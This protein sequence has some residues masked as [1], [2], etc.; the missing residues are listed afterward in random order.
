MKEPLDFSSIHTACLSGANGHGKSALLDAITW[1]LWGRARGV[2]RRGT[3]ADDLIHFRQNYMQVELTFELENQL[4][5]VVRFR[6]KSGR[7]QSRLELQIKSNDQFHSL[8]CSSIPETQERI[9]RL[10]RMDYETFTNSAFILQGKADSFTTKNPNDRKEILSEILGLSLYDKLEVKAKE[11]RRESDKSQAVIESKID[12][13]DQEIE[14]EETLQDRLKNLDSQLEAVRKQSRQEEKVLSGL[15]EQKTQFDI[16]TE[17]LK[18][19][20]A[21]VNLIQRDINSLSNQTEEYKEEI[22][23]AQN[24]ICQA[25]HINKSYQELKELQKASKLIDQIRLA[26]VVLSQAKSELQTKIKTLEQKEKEKALQIITAKLNCLREDYSTL[27]NKKAN[28]AAEN[29]SLTKESKKLKEKITLIS[30]KTPACPFCRQPLDIQ[31]R[32][33]LL[34]EFKTQLA[35]YQEQITLSNQEIS[36]LE[37]KQNQIN[38]QGNQLKTVLDTSHRI[39]PNS[40]LTKIKREPQSEKLTE[41]IH[42]REELQIRLREQNYAPEEQKKIRELKNK[43]SQ[44][45]CPA[46]VEYEN[47][48]SKIE[49]LSIYEEKRLKLSNSQEQLA[50][51]KEKLAMCQSQKQEKIKLYQDDLA[52]KKTLTQEISQASGLQT[53]IKSLEVE[54]GKVIQK[55]R[56]LRSH[57]AIA[58]KELQRCQKLAEERGELLA[59]RENLGK[60][61][62]IYSELAAAFSKKGIQALIIENAVPEIEEEANK[63]LERLTEGRMNVHFETQKDQKTGKVVET[64]DLVISDGELGERK[65]E[66][67]SGGEAFRINFAVRIALSKLLAKRAGARL[68]TLVVD[69]GFGTQD[70][71]GKEKL[72]EVIGAIQSDFKKILVITHLEDLKEMF[73]AR[74]EVVKKSGVGSIATLV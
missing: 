5:R 57:V 32:E 3:G 43:L 60:E 17:Q 46:T 24:I 51:L 10:L 30:Q 4:Y 72:V 22:A 63:L 70:E 7:G 34:S 14:Q 71:E 8:T 25:S 53:E 15:K 67:Y 66:L 28:L 56:E 41:L 13:L 68:E 29:K 11:K 36:R 49:E 38:R 39:S 37:A 31:H 42:K 69:E 9:N 54:H 23:Q 62:N 55:E 45:A 52:K 61:M 21:R 35:N 33:S 26:E 47:L 1:A 27:E 12:R 50:K 74:I 20:E 73:P 18:D 40:L 65:Y 6:D 2:D 64:L 16:Q 48:E 58:Q 59:Q 19:L 44:L